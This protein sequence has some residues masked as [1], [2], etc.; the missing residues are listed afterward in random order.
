M[1]CPVLKPTQ[2]ESNPRL[3][4][5]SPSIAMGEPIVGSLLTHDGMVH[6]L[7]EAAEAGPERG[8]ALI[9]HDVSEVFL[10]YRELLRCATIRLGA[11]Q[12]EGLQPGATAILLQNE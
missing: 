7:R 6:L 12:R 4:S 10:S 2:D 1:T 11:L 9:Q 5:A 8:I 3:H